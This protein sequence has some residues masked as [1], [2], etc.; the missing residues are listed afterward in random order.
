MDTRSDLAKGR[1]EINSTTQRTRDKQVMNPKSVSCS[2]K[3]LNSKA[4]RIRFNKSSFKM[5]IKI[6]T[7]TGYAKRPQSGAR[8]LTVI[9]GRWCSPKSPPKTLL[10]KFPRSSGKRGFP[11]AGQSEET[12][13]ISQHSN[14]ALKGK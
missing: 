7:G 6:V 3:H 13:W 2:G 1:K 9:C 4:S 14:Q 12:S 8:E 11:P 5:H 10:I